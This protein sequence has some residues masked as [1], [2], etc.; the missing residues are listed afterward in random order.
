MKK[1]RILIAT[2]GSDYGNAAVVK[3]CDLIDPATT[4]VRVMFAYPEARPIPA[5]PAF[6]SAKYYNEMEKDVKEAARMVVS[7]AEHR[8]RHH[9]PGAD[10]DLKAIVA[11]G[12]PDQQITELARKW[13]ADL[14]VVGSHGYGFWG[15]LLGSVSDGV[16]HHSPCSVL[17]VKSN[18]D[19]RLTRPH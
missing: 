15:R 10:L 4:S 17:V 9:F 16:V 1:T 18:G 19:A 13:K 12:H 6:M 3:A 7:D 5:E 11:R 2:D 8:I 14:V